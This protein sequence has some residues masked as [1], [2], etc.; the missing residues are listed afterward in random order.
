VITDQQHHV[1]EPMQYVTRQVIRITMMMSTMQGRRIVVTIVMD[2]VVEVM[3]I[4]MIGN[5]DE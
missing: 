5:M 1:E 3:V 2:L 4:V